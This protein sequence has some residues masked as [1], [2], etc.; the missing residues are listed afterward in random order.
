MDTGISASQAAM[1]GV[2]AAAAVNSLLNLS[3]PTTLWAMANQLQ[4]L[5]LLILMKCEIP[6]K[7]IDFI[8]ANKFAMISLDFLNLPDFSFMPKSFIEK[9]QKLETLHT[10]GVE[11]GSAFANNFSLFVILFCLIPIHIGIL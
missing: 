9:D 4:L 3:S 10:V 6:Q 2:A 1:G 8:T 5:L 7:I 11:S